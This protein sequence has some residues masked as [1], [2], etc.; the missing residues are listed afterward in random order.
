MDPAITAAAINAAS[1]GFNA[2]SQIN[3]NKQSRRY[4]TYMYDRQR[5]DAI[6]DWNKQAAYNSPTAQ[7]ARLKEAGLNP[8]LVY[9]NGADAQMS[10]GVRSSSAPGW[11]PHPATFDG[12]SVM[13]SYFDARIKSASYDNLLEQQKVLQSQAH[14][15]YA[16][17][18]QATQH[19]TTSAI[20]NKTRQ[21]INETTLE[22]MRA[23]IDR[24][25]A[26]IGKITADTVLA[27]T[28]NDIKQAMKQPN[29]DLVMQE[30]LSKQKT[31]ALQDSQ[32]G[33]NAVESRKRIVEMEELRQKIH[34]LYLDGQ[35]KDFD[36][37]LKQWRGEGSDY[38]GILKFLSDFI[39]TIMD[40]PFGG[41]QKNPYR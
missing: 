30:I 33:L 21:E 13:G 4:A 1:Q 26:E 27:G 37:E 3:M 24:T 12:G 29:I 8:N 25:H 32:I 19:G 41:I 22:G 40:R 20:D 17:A 2:F 39:K 11:N 14:L 7:M 9:G 10:Q 36:L 18:F 5:A 34:N 15:N 35:L 28:E 23:N 38:P 6:A 31:R 16:N